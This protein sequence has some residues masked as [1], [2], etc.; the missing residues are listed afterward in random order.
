MAIFGSAHSPSAPGRF[1][2]AAAH[3]PTHGFL[4]SGVRTLRPT[5]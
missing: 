2:R 3:L 1:A 4:S 5:V